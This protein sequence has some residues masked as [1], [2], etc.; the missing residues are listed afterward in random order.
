MK[1]Y[2]VYAEISYYDDLIVEADNEAEAIEEAY[3]S[4]ANVL[5]YSISVE[6]IE[7]EED[8]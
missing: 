6:E 4:I 7:D 3:E 1:R 2:K 5:N 8:E